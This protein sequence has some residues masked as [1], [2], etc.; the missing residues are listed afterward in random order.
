MTRFNV[1]RIMSFIIAGAALS[2]GWLKMAAYEDFYRALPIWHV[3]GTASL[4]FFLLGGAVRKA[5]NRKKMQKQPN[6]RGDG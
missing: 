2:F 5:R 6:A 4:F 3:G 1:F